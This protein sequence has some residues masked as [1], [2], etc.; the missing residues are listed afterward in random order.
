[1]DPYVWFR[2]YISPGVWYSGWSARGCGDGSCNDTTLRSPRVPRRSR[3]G[4]V[5]TRYIHVYS[6]LAAALW[7]T[8]QRRYEYVATVIDIRPQSYH[9]WPGMKQL[10]IQPVPVWFSLH[11][12]Y[13]RV[14]SMLEYKMCKFSCQSEITFLP[15]KTVDILVRVLH[16]V[17]TAGIKEAL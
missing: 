4:T 14:I 6:S 5:T 16:V 10:H 3:S 13:S 17:S 11:C 7:R 12:L 8:W 1:M 2:G 15:N 9:S